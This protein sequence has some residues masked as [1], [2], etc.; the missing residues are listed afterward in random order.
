MNKSAKYAAALALTLIGAGVILVI[1]GLLMG[2]L[3]SVHFGIN[4][5]YI[6]DETNDGAR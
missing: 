1:A 5:F 2:G 3:R 6:A 4:G